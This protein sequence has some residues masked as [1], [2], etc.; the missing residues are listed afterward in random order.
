LIRIITVACLAAGVLAPAPVAGH[1]YKKGELR[2]GHP[3]TRA[4]PPAA[5]VAAGYLTIRN[6]GKQ[7]DRIL[8]ASTPAAERVELHIQIRE[9]DVLKMREVRNFEIPAGGRLTLRPGGSHLMLVGLK[10]PLVKGQTI[11]LT[12]RFER[13]GELHAEVEVQAADTATHSHN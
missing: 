12:V 4:T 2:V 13:A 8:G 10:R 3:W 1:E 6:S 11:P 5:K 7:P 9:G